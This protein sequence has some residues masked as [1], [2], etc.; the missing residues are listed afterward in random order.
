MEIRLNILLFL[1]TVEYLAATKENE[2]FLYVLMWG[3]LD[4]VLS[5]KKELQNMWALYFKEIIHICWQAQ[6][7]FVSIDNKLDYMLWG[8]H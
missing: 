7:I 5:E 2:K 4:K 8:E 3:L 6:N 1:H